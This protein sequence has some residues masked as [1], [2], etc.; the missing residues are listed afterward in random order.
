MNKNKEVMT[1]FAM[2]EKE[3]IE[4]LKLECEDFRR[5]H[6]P[7]LSN[8]NNNSESVTLKPTELKTSN[9]NSKKEIEKIENNNQIEVQEVKLAMDSNISI[10]NNN[11]PPQVNIELT[12]QNNLDKINAPVQIENSFKSSMQEETNNKSM[13]KKKKQILMDEHLQTENNVLMTLPEGSYRPAQQVKSSDVSNRSNRIGKN[14]NYVSPMPERRNSKPYIKPTLQLD[15][16]KILPELNTLNPSLKAITSG[17]G[18]TNTV[19]NRRRKS[20]WYKRDNDD[21]R[22]RRDWRG[23]RGYRRGGIGQKIGG[24]ALHHVDEEELPEEVDE[25]IRKL[26]NSKDSSKKIVILKYL[27]VALFLLTMYT[28]ST[29]W[30]YYSVVGEKNMLDVIQLIAYQSFSTRMLYFLFLENLNRGYLI[31]DQTGKN[32]FA[33]LH[34]ELYE[35]SPRV[36]DVLSSTPSTFGDFEDNFRKVYY[37]SVCTYYLQPKLN[38]DCSHDATFMSGL[39]LLNIKIYEFANQNLNL[40]SGGNNNWTQ[41]AKQMASSFLN[42]SLPQMEQT[43][44][45]SRIIYD[46]ILNNYSEGFLSFKSRQ[47]GIANLTLALWCL[48]IIGGFIFIWFKYIKDLNKS[49]WRIQGLLNMI[50]VEIIRDNHH[51]TVRYKL[52][53]LSKGN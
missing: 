17:G 14:V 24:H 37:Q 38:I 13:K 10:N 1:L 42:N 20:H 22:N 6:L 44:N 16:E 40:I 52:G 32:L 45:Y 25:R 15:S 4:K 51:M 50:P 31:L 9:N 33:K 36:D 3:Q 21:D 35:L 46:D 41:E 47:D 8:Q 18:N 26:K 11:N 39:E 29:L 49:I 27:G 19:R 2:I 5:N 48:V 12:E 7:E 53:I 28:G 43:F 34:D 23:E 30:I